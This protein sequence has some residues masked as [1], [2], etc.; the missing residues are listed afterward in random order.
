MKTEKFT[1]K[2]SCQC[3]ACEDA[4]RQATSARH[5][6]QFQ[7][8][9]DAL[10][11]ARQRLS[12]PNTKASAAGSTE[13]PMRDLDTQSPIVRDSKD[14]PEIQDKVRQL[15]LQAKAVGT[16]PSSVDGGAF[17]SRKYVTPAERQFATAMEK[18]AGRL[19]QETG[20]QGWR[21]VARAFRSIATGGRL[22]VK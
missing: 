4:R 8:M 11:G 3:Q 13:R 7:P 12:N 9:A 1:P 2:P 19:A 22:G 16:I 18:S 10:C 20:D 6:P 14:L 21:K 17:L 15:I 5:N